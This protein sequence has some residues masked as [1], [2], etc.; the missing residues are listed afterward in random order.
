MDPQIYPTP[1]MENQSQLNIFLSEVRTT[2]SELRMG[3]T[4]LT[5]KVDALQS[6]V[7]KTVGFW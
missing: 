2:N 1:Q 7:S 5:D 6:K 4:R 3:I